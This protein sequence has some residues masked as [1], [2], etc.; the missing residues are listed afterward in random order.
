MDSGKSV[1]NC[2]RCGQPLPQGSELPLCGACVLEDALKLSDPSGLPSPPCEVES[3]SPA[4]LGRLGRYELVE[5]LGRG[6]MGAVY[7]ARQ[8]GSDGMVA[9][10]VLAGGVFAKDKDRERLNREA[11]ALMR[12]RHPGIVEIHEVGAVDG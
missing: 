1:R 7:K 5:L 12:L 2:Q 10:K 6:G 11:Q 8:Q 9:V 3:A 4:P